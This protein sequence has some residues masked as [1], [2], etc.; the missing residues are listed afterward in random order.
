MAAMSDSTVAASR[1]KGDAEAEMA[2]ARAAKLAVNF[3]ANKGS[4]F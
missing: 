3:I 2:R 1:L 4:E